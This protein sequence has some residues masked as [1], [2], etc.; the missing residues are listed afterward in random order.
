M[1]MDSSSGDAYKVEAYVLEEIFSEWGD[2]PSMSEVDKNANSATTSKETPC[3]STSMNAEGTKPEVSTNSTIGNV[4]SATTSI[5]TPSTSTATNDDEPEQE[6]YTTSST[7]RGG[8]EESKDD[9]Q[10]LSPLER[11]RPGYLWVT[12]LTRQN[13]C[14]QQLY[15]SFTIPTIAE[16]NPV[17]TAGTDYHL[18]RELATHDIVKVDVQS[19]E[20]IWAV[21]MLNLHS[22]VCTFL[23]G[24]IVARE[25]PVFGA[26]FKED[27]LIVGLIDELRFDPSNYTIDLIELKTR[28]SSTMPSRSQRKQHNFQVSVY[29]T[30][31]DDLVQG[32]VSKQFM[33]STLKINL[34][35]ELGDSIRGHAEKQFVVIKSLNDLM[36]IIFHKIQTLTCI[37]QVFIEY[38]HQESKQ[39]IGH[40]EVE[41]DAVKVSDLYKKYV[42]FW[43]G[44]RRA[45]GV[46]IED[47]WKCQRCDFNS[48]CEWRKKKSAECEQRN[49]KNAK[50]K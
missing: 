20:D 5:D 15:Y 9:D 19:S 24:G 21:K 4:S 25:V 31:F 47:A 33:A 27:I 37:S 48:I 38:V 26:P 7:R 30:L 18:A 1:H 32:K 49:K 10:C 50:I 6:A 28:L 36:D 12:D 41:Y 13:W 17:M 42:K 34:H 14:E 11:F 35:K 3:F 29:K 16:E 22:A 46:D 23:H 40:M 39:T 45:D 43:R 44:N 8:A 2:P